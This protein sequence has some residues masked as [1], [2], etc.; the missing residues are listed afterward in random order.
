MKRRAFNR[1]LV[2]DGRE[3]MG[4]R[5]Q[6]AGGDGRIHP[7]FPP[8]VRPHRRSDGPRDGAPRQS[9]TVNSS[10]TLRPSARLWVN[11]GWWASDG[12]RPQ[13]RQGCWATDLTCSRSRTR[14]GSGKVST[15]LSICPW[16]GPCPSFVRPTRAAPCCRAPLWSRLRLV[17]RKGSKSRRPSL[18]GLLHAL[19]IRRC[20]PLLLG[21]G[22]MCPHCGVLAAGER[23]ETCEQPIPQLSRRY[24]SSAARSANPP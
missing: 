12:S 14:R 1:C 22:A 4:R 21:Q 5:P 18:E 19:A 13:T 2:L 11:R 16:S 24:R 6:H 17:R 3:G 10:L 9:G 15:L 20:R 23:I 7:S 8:P